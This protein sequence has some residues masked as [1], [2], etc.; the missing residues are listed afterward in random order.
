MQ[1]EA[2]TSSSQDVVKWLEKCF[3][4]QSNDFL[5]YYDISAQKVPAASDLLM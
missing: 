5:Q 1:K 2:V 3:T 4:V